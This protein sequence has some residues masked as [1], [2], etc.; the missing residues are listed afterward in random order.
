MNSN[1]FC[2]SVPHVMSVVPLACVAMADADGH[3]DAGALASANHHSAA[4]VAGG[5]SDTG[6]TLPR[7]PPAAPGER[8][9][10]GEDEGEGASAA[11]TAKSRH[12]YDTQDALELRNLTKED[13]SRREYWEERFKEE[14]EYDWLCDYSTLEPRLLRY[15]AGPP[16]GTGPGAL[17]RIL[18][19]GCGNSTFS[20]E[21]YDAGFHNI[22]NIDFAASVIARMTVEHAERRPLMRWLEMDMLDM[23]AFPDESFDIVI[24]KGSLDA[25]QAAI[26]NV[27]EPS[28]ECRAQA[29]TFLCETRRVLH[30]GSGGGGGGGGGGRDAGLFFS[31]SFEQPHFRTKFLAGRADAFETDPYRTFDGFVREYGWD[32]HF[33]DVG[34]AGCLSV[35]VYTMRVCDEEPTPPPA[36]AGVAGAPLLAATA[37]A[38]EEAEGDDGEQE[39]PVAPAGGHVVDN[40]EHLSHVRHGIPS[41]DADLIR[42]GFPDNSDS[43]W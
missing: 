39:G 31:V 22:T 42:N 2:C 37:A 28:A 10:D 36:R 9:T 12:T 3:S 13:F 15:L 14:P 40:R 26:K 38:V 23:S 17:A 32:L 34:A 25:L 1:S 5:D 6:P 18:V 41:T 4:P 20:A 11:V 35:F 19:I 16:A 33:Q 30:G 24:D 29:H 43:S 8:S 21:L 7:P 27:W